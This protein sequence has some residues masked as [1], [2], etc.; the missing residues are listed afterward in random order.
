[1]SGP[2]LHI[3]AA[4]WH[5]WYR[6]LLPAYWIFLFTCTHLPDLELGGPAGVSDKVMHVLA[7]GGLAFAFW[8]FCQ[9]LLT[10][11]PDYFV[12]IAAIILIVYTAIDEH[13]QAYVGRGVDIRDFLFGTGGIIAVLAILEW[14]RRKTRP[15]A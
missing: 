8:R 15:A 3:P 6:H 10:P 1:M 4:S 12:F 7:F 2:W 14:R 11:L 13:T 9:T 5:R